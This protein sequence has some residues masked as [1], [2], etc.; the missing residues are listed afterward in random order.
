MFQGA[1]S[2]A[3][4]ICLSTDVKPVTAAAIREFG[5]KAGDIVIETDTGRKFRF[6]GD[7]VAWQPADE[8]VQAAGK[9]REIASSQETEVATSSEIYARAAGASDIGVYV[10]SGSVR[11]RTDG[12][13]ATATT[14]IPLG[15]GF[16][17]FWVVAA[18]SVYYV[19]DST[20]TVVSR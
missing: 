6:D 8:G 3:R 13:Q 4:F 15:E 10:E 20:I 19:A 14:G 12:L 18:I 16:F 9:K 17:E 2:E 11:V 1:G 7:S 5:I